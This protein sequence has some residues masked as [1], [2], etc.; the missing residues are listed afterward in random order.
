MARNIPNGKSAGRPNGIEAVA[1]SAA[2]NPDVVV[3]DLTMPRMNGFEAAPTIHAVAP[4][5]P[6]LLFTQHTFVS[7]PEHEARNSEFTWQSERLV[8][9]AY[10]RSRIPAP[11]R[12]FL[13]TCLE[14]RGVGD[15]RSGNPAKPTKRE[16]R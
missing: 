13:Q 5:L 11:R 2:L 7:H 16:E 6:L 12:N 10:C 8:R 1:Q 4:K 15:D 3:L 14:S 9:L